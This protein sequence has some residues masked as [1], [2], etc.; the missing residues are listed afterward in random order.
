MFPMQSTIPNTIC[1]P[2]MSL[3]VGTS[4]EHGSVLRR[5]CHGRVEQGENH[6]DETPWPE[7]Q[8]ALDAFDSE[9]TMVK[10]NHGRMTVAE[11]RL[12]KTSSVAEPVLERT[13]TEEESHGGS[14]ARGDDAEREP[15]TSS[16][17]GE[18]VRGR[19][20]EK[21]MV[22]RGRAQP[23]EVQVN[24]TQPQQKGPPWREFGKG[25]C[26]SMGQFSFARDWWYIRL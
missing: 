21:T 16:H 9:T 11:A 1:S 5:K 8:E 7:V 4:A 2:M 17:D 22:D 14:D 20:T 26:A 6:E 18:F 3:Q 19:V 23:L 24:G 10:N 13:T 25:P 12:E 15:W